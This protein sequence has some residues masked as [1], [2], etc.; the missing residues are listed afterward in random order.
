MLKIGG[1]IGLAASAMLLSIIWL[2]PRVAQALETGRP[3]TGY[4]AIGDV[5][6]KPDQPAMTTDEQSKLKKE[7]SAARDRQVPKDNSRT[8]PKSN[9]GKAGTG[10]PRN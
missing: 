9:K 8:G 7:L 3:A 5:P 6:P 10:T 2:L 4:P 1:S